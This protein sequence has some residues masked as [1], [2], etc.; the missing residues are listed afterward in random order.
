MKIIIPRALL[1]ITHSTTWTTTFEVFDLDTPVFCNS[2]MVRIKSLENY[3]RLP[4]KDFLPRLANIFR[5][6]AYCWKV[7]D[8]DNGVEEVEV[9]VFKTTVNN[10][11]FSC[12]RMPSTVSSMKRTRGAT[13]LISMRVNS[14]SR[15]GKVFLLTILISSSTQVK[16]RAIQMIFVAI[17]LQHFG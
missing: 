17:N 2:R 9:S 3:S 7:V 14:K 16:N 11:N 12:F 10:C 15:F 6:S 1:C 5:E 4:E 8:F 13:H